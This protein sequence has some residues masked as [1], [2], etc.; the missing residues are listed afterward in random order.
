MGV[1][2]GQGNDNSHTFIRVDAAFTTDV[3]TAGDSKVLPLSSEAAVT[4]EPVHP[5]AL[6]L[7]SS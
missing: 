7:T 3:T 5:N 6:F 4:V 2:G 1:G